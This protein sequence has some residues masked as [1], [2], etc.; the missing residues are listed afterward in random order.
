MNKI[1]LIG[2][3]NVAS[4]LGITLK[5]KG[6]E[7][8]QVYSKTNSSSSLL[9]KKLNCD[10]TTDIKE[11]K[12]EA[13]LYIISVK[14][15]AIN[16]IVEQFPYENVLVAHTSGSVDIDVFSKK[17]IRPAVI[18]P[19]Q[20][21]SKDFLV[22]VSNSP[23]L[24]EAANNEDLLKIKKIA[25]EISD[26]VIHADSKQRS[27]SHLAAVFACNFSNHLFFIAED[28]LKKNNLSFD[29]LKPL[30]KETFRKIESNSPYEVQ[31]GP[32]VRNDKNIIKKHSELLSYSDSY[33]KIYNFISD[34]IVLNHLKKTDQN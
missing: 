9:A 7:I 21:F 14:D 25:S 34:N 6:K 29:I 16:E 31:T 19:L 4:N 15:S 11:L 20:T 10:Y 12:E 32:A 30:I 1:V 3:G 18:Y 17:N 8:V 13:D 2:A 27:F 26:N 24:V 28:I 5:E 33:Q 23:I 22:D